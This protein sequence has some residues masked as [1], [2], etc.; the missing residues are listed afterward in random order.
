MKTY[1]FDAVGFNILK[2]ELSRKGAQFSILLCTLVTLHPKVREGSRHQKQSVFH[3]RSSSVS[4]GHVAVCP[5]QQLNP[6]RES[7]ADKKV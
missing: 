7:Q 2:K 5:R 4:L 1:S 6:C 3:P